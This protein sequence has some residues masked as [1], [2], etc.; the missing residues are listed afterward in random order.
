L[1]SLNLDKLSVICRDLLTYVLYIIF[2]TTLKVDTAVVKKEIT[3]T[4]Y[5]G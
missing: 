4:S 1:T 3:F 2:Q 5:D